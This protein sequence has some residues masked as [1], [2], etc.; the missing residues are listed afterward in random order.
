M[1]P[2]GTLPQFICKNCNQPAITKI[3]KNGANT[4]KEY[5]F[6]PYCPDKKGKSGK[7]LE[8]CPTFFDI[9]PLENSASYTTDGHEETVLLNLKKATTEYLEILNSELTKRRKLSHYK[10]PEIFNS[11]PRLTPLN[12]PG[13]ATCL[14]PSNFLNKHDNSGC[15]DDVDNDGNYYCQKC[16]EERDQFLF[17]QNLP[18]NCYKYYEYRF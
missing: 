4:G 15:V 17:L 13:P 5:Y 7:F 8:W 12:L 18:E 14:A 9:K 2:R 16:N 6:C 1:D 3:T 10:T 11:D